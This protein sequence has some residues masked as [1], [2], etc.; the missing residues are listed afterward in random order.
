MYDLL[1]DKASLDE[2]IVKT[3]FKNLSIISAFI[4]LAGVDIELMERSRIDRSF[5]RSTQQKKFRCS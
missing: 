3:D 5:N 1:V 2:V 4:Y